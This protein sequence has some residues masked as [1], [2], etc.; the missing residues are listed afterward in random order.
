MVPQEVWRF[1]L[2]KERNVNARAPVFADGRIYQVFYFGRN[3]DKSTLIAF[4]AE[5]GHEI[6]RVDFPDCIN[7]PVVG[8]SGTIYVS[9]LGGKAYAHDKNGSELWSAYV[10]FALRRPC[11]AGPN[12]LILVEMHGRAFRTFCLDSSTGAINWQ[13][14]KPGHRFDIGA[15]TDVVVHVTT[16]AGASFDDKPINHLIALSADTGEELWAIRSETYLLASMIIDDLVI[17]GARGSLRAFEMKAGKLVAQFPIQ[18]DAA[19][20]NGLSS[21]SDGFVFFD[22]SGTI[23]C[24]S[25]T[26]KRSLLRSALRFDERWSNSL[27]VKLLGRPATFDSTIIVLDERGHFHHL[28]AE[29]GRRL[30][31]FEMGTGDTQANGGV[32]EVGSL[33]AASHGRMLALYRI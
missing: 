12:R 5:A 13:F 29:N 8:A 11:L 30:Y 15:T 2:A 31:S 24:V 21:V 27:P 4:D 16:E 28:S 26:K 20:N 1:R 33:L 23:Q 14:D 22:D 25:L 32:A 19:I 10:G 18:Q 7:E 6:W 9:S 17:V 3:P